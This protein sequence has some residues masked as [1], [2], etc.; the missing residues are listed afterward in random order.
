MRRRDF[1]KAIASSTAWPLHA[2][3]QSPAQI[4]TV[5]VLWHAASAQEEQPYFDAL[6]QG[7]KE[8]GYV[9]G[10]NIRFEHRFPNE[11]PE[12][13]RQMAAELVA[14]N[15]AAI[16]TVGNTTAQYAKQATNSIPV[17]FVFVNDPVAAKLVDTLA[18]PGGNVTGYSVVGID[19]TAK[20]FELLREI[21]PQVSRVGLLLNPAEPSAA[22]YFAEGRA[23]AAALN[24]T[25]E[26]F[27][28]RA[29]NEMDSVFARMAQSGVQALALGPGGLLFQGKSDLAKTALAHR[30]P[31]CGWSRETLVSGLLLSYG[32]DLVQI[33]RQAATFVDKILRGTRPGD[34]P[35]QQPTRFQLVVNQKTAKALNITIP[36]SFFLRADE[37]ID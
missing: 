26:P 30:I 35:V 15:V 13:F 2:Q 8:L 1:I 7:F 6:I 23:A 24:L 28:L 25:V 20:R 14:L 22:Q 29:L 12:R 32:P 9:E 5:G 17:V 11:I 21:V 18:R 4:P 34:L 31:T 37:V 33:V 10:R 27:E 16:V 36:S 19:L 3:A